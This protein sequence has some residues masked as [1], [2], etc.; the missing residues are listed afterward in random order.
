M[1][2]ILLARKAELKQIAELIIDKQDVVYFDYPLHL[3]VGDLLIY[4]GTEQFFKDYDIR[5]RLRR[6]LQAFDID[7]AKKYITP[8]TTILCHGGGNFGDLYPSIQKMR[9]DIVQYF[10]QNRIILLPQTAHFSN[11]AAM[12]LSAKIFSAH[13]DLHLFARDI[14]T[15]DLMK[16]HFSSN[17]ALSADMAHELYGTLAQK[18]RTK[19][20]GKTLYFLRKDIEKSHIE[21]QVQ[22]KLSH[23]ED[24]KDWD[25]ILLPSDMKFEL[26]CSRLSKLANRF[27]FGWLKDKINEM[28]YQHAMQVIE[29][30]Q[31]VFLS[32]DNVVTSRLHGHIFSCLLGLPN[33]VCDNSYGKNTGYYHQWT[34]DID[35]AK[36][37]QL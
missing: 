32:Y 15:F 35:Y 14:K 23:L 28:W 6:S 2:E 8:N 19:S 30:C 33:E 20:N 1:N 36:I 31:A 9:E 24:V 21:A 37:Y 7:E 10:P 34:K 17:V 11:E 27:H 13:P 25:D 5:I 12:L 18:D 16:A 3:N 22:A 4:A 26:W 29:R